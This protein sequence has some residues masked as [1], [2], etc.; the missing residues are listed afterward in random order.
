MTNWN[1]YGDVI[2]T[3][4][5]ALDTAL[6]YDVSETVVGQKMKELP[7]GELMK[8]LSL[9]DGT[10]LNGRFVVTIS[11]NA[12]VVSVKDRSGNTPSTASPVI[13]WINGTP[14]AITGALSITVPAGVNTFS[15]G[16]AEI[17]TNAID[18]FVYFIWNTG[19]ATDVI[20]IGLSRL[21]FG[22]I[23]SQFSATETAETYL[24]YGNA[25]SPASTDDVANAGRIRATL[26]LSGTGH[27]WTSI[28]QSAPSNANTLHEPTFTTGLLS[29]TP[30]PTYAGGTT[31]PTSNTVASA[32]YTLDG[33][34]LSLRIQSALVR[35]AGDRTSTIFTTPFTVSGI[36]PASATDEITAA[37]TKNAVAAYLSTNTFVVVETMANNGNY[38][39][40]GKAII[41]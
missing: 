23:K 25:T 32:T 15:A 20:D 30:A 19:P 26:S 17:G 29:W 9:P 22:R 1:D 41:T 24:A 3:E 31:N 8:Y 10:M 12:L 14:R 13:V 34:D 27:L 5:S 11:S 33:R 35:G 39:C 21:P 40:Y 2:Y 28:S 4:L 36:T 18:L 16:G 38:Y 7:L 37:G 6:I